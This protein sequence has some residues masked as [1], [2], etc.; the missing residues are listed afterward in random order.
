MEGAQGNVQSSKQ[1]LAEVKFD[2]STVNNIRNSIADQQK[3]RIKHKMKFFSC[4]LGHKTVACLTKSI[5]VSNLQPFHQIN[6]DPRCRGS[7]NRHFTAA[8]I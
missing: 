3:S 1:K 8:M 2:A 6:I 4:G 7:K 5:K